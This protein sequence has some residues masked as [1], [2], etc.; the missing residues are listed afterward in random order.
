MVRQFS[1]VANGT[2]TALR[3]VYVSESALIDLPMRVDRLRHLL[4]PS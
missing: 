4:H 1:Q 3:Y 2:P